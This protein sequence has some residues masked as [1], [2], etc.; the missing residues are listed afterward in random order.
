MARINDMPIS[1]N[2]RLR[3]FHCRHCQ[4]AKLSPTLIQ[5][6]QRIRDETGRPI[7]IT[8]GYRCPTHNRNVGGAAG[9]MH[10]RGMAADFR[11]VGMST[12]QAYQIALRHFGRGGVARGRTFVHGDVRWVIGRPPARWT[13]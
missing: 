6:M 10:L 8:S 4:T 7:V 2:F 13:Y 5:I 11:I 12:E 1:R 3:E 9:S